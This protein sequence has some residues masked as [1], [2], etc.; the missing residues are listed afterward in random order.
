MTSGQ[1]RDWHG[2]AGRSIALC[3]RFKCALEQPAAW[4][5]RVRV[6]FVTHD[7]VLGIPRGLL[8]LQGTQYR[9]RSHQWS[10][11]RQSWSRRQQ[12]VVQQA[13]GMGKR[14]VTA[15]RHGVLNCQ[16]APTFTTPVVCRLC[17][18]VPSSTNYACRRWLQMAYTAAPEWAAG[19]PLT[20]PRGTSIRFCT[21]I[22]RPYPRPG[23]FLAQSLPSSHPHVRL[24]RV[25]HLPKQLILSFYKLDGEY[26]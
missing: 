10:S 20:I 16:G 13:F 26:L 9:K 21:C 8:R 17:L 3:Y 25:H 1:V 7:A 23:P 12:A 14:C 4:S 15:F 11:K 18:F 22:D 5:W 24:K 2:N 19:C 6:V